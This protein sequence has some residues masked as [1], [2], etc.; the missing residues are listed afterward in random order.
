MEN[1]GT[2]PGGDAPP[3]PTDSKVSKLPADENAASSENKEEAPSQAQEAKLHSHHK[4]KGWKG[5]LKSMGKFIWNSETK[6]VCGRGLRRWAL[7]VIFYII[8]YVTLACI[9]T[10][11]LAIVLGML[12]KDSPQQVYKDQD[13]FYHKSLIQRYPAVILTP[14]PDREKNKDSPLI[15]ISHSAKER[16]AWGNKVKHEMEGYR[17][18]LK[19]HPKCQKCF[20]LSTIDQSCNQ[21]N[22]GYDV[23]Q[24][25]FLIRL[26][27]M[28]EWKP[29]Y[30]KTQHA[31]E[32]Y[33]HR[34]I[35]NDAILTQFKAQV[36]Q[37]EWKP[38]DK[39]VPVLCAGNSVADDQLLNGIKYCTKPFLDG[40]L[41]P[42]V[43]TEPY[44]APFVMIQFLNAV[45]GIPITVA[46]YPI[47][48]GL[49]VNDKKAWSKET[50]EFMMA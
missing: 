50:F 25:T 8:F 28:L 34:T 38:G 4:Q 3:K 48:D 16:K 40:K 14:L 21:N 36:E 35:K 9:F 23:R 44:L 32:H 30:F 41:F 5:V 12:D 29:K 1:E 31:A 7:L 19:K 33:I 39:T 37:G 22:Y 49:K 43:N 13:S 15:W 42:F 2:K 10:G 24:P 18:Y 47:L 45:P 26:S 27:K 17:R 46:C 20:E 11:L 6:Q